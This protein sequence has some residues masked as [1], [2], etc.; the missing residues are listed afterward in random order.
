MA[1]K[2]IVVIWSKHSV[3]S[4]W[5]RTEASEGADRGILFPVLTEDVPIPLAF[6]RIQAAN[7]AEWDGSE[8][9]SAFQRLVADIAGILGP[10][11][12][13]VKEEQ[14]KS[15]ELSERERREEAERPKVEEVAAKRKAALDAKRKADEGAGLKAEEETAK[16][17]TEDEPASRMAKSER[18]TVP[19]VLSR[20]PLTKIAFL[21][22]VAVV[23][24]V[25]VVMISRE[26]EPAREPYAP[27]TDAP[28]KTVDRLS[29]TEKTEHLPVANPKLI[30]RLHGSN[31]EGT[32]LAPALATSYLQQLG[33]T[34]T[35]AVTT[36]DLVEEYIQGYLPKTQEVVAVEIFA[37]GPGSSFKDLVARQAD[38]AMSSIPIKAKERRDLK[39]LFGDLTSEKNEIIVGSDGLAIIVNRANPVESLTTKQIAGLLSGDIADWSQVGGYA[40]PVNV[41]ARDELSGAFDTIQHLV[42]RPH[43]K[44]FSN[45]AKRYKSVV[46][47]ADA[48]AND[49]SGIGFVGLPFAQ[50][51]K[52]IAVAD[53]DEVAPLLPTPFTVATE[54]YPLTRRLYFYVPDIS[55]NP[56]ARSIADFALSQAG[57]EIVEREGFVSHILHKAKPAITQAMPY[58]YVSLIRNAE[59]LSLNFRF[60]T[61]SLDLDT[62]SKQDF[63]RLLGYMQSRADKRLILIG[64]TDSIGSVKNNLR[65]SEERTVVVKRMLAARNVNTQVVKGFGEIRPIATN[66]TEEGR[67]HNRRIEVWIQ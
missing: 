46:A 48:V 43:N 55:V 23:V 30:L 15:A 20:S 42:L 39:L 5:V 36:Q 27:T 52:T 59:R 21:G 10:P 4:R 18:N 3:N 1:A 64:F 67:Y 28:A 53:S 54:D 9:H 6:K 12:V 60:Q 57:Q 63:K 11:P 33:A 65:L 7:L 2:C 44:R 13:A 41:H 16:R 24:V 62:K 40:G 22:G 25:I 38:I 50:R 19:P 8:S 66:M 58:S 49:R 51:A 29:A 47:L 35:V 61:G 45:S 34:E 14:R 17:K 37:H 32:R 31:I 56:H 26:L